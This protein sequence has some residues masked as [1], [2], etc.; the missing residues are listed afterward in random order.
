MLGWRRSGLSPTPSGGRG[1][2]A[3]ERIG[4]EQQQHA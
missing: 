2:Q 1:V 3:L 4:E